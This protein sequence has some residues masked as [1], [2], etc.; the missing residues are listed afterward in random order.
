MIGKQVA[1]GTKPSNTPA[2]TATAEEW[3]KNR[4]EAADEPAKRLTLDIPESLH[5][6]IKVSCANRGTQMAAEIRVLL[7]A[8][9]AKQ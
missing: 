8:H 3:I 4:E 2:A 5:R 9:Y 7:K 1:F 6:A